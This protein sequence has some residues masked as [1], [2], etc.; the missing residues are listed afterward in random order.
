MMKMN[1][2]IAIIGFSLTLTACSVTRN[3]QTPELSNSQNYRGNHSTDTTSIADIPWRTYFSDTILQNLIDQ[4]LNNNLD[5]K[6]AI[7]R[8]KYADANFKQSQLAFYPSVSA[9]A[10]NTLTKTYSS[11]SS[12][13]FLTNELTLSASASWEVDL[14]GK[15]KSN[16][17]A[18]LAALLAS[19]AYK[20]SVQTEIV[21]SLA[22]NYYALMA[23]DEQ[24]QIAEQTLEIRKTDTATMRDL[25]TYAVVNG[26]DVEQSIAN[27]YA[28]EIEA[29]GIKKSIRETENAISIL[30]GQMPNNI[31]RSTLKEQ[32]ISNDLRVGIPLQL[33]SH[34]PDIQQAEFNFRNAYELTN[35]ARTYF[36]PTLTISGNGGVS[37]VNTLKGIFDG[38]FYANLIGGLAQPIFNKG[39]NKQRLAQ[40]Q[41]KQEESLYEFQSAMLTASQE[42]ANALYSYQNAANLFTSRN[43]RIASL[44]KATEYT[45]ELLKYTS[46]VNYTDVLT[47][48]TNLLSAKLGRV[49]D[50][51]QQLQ[52]TVNLYRA[53]GGGWK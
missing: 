47:A 8:I 18:S 53:L 1:K 17:K 6:V 12:N 50:K 20:R 3:Y 28:A 33:I 38:S 7:T 26:A 9:N 10:E 45:K 52:A 37:S 27:M 14:W 34:R 49:G 16:E 43:H 31:P 19:D 11:S 32:V 46:K 2:I 13:S 30:L 22:N 4:A 44:E 21:A 23:Y 51:L 35:V 29:E 25:K 24:L 48:E 42:V 41:A 39:L 5:L 40:A 15:I 36:Y